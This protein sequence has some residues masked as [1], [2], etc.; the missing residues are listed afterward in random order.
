MI[1]VVRPTAVAAS[2]G[3]SVSTVC[4]NSVQSN[5]SGF[6]SKL[7]GS[8]KTT[9]L[10][11]SARVAQWMRRRSPKP[12]IGGSSPPVGTPAFQSWEPVPHLL[13]SMYIMYDM[14]EKRGNKIVYILHKVLR[15]QPI[16]CQFIMLNLV[17]VALSISEWLNF[18]V[19]LPNT[20]SNPLCHPL[21]LNNVPSYLLQ[22]CLLAGQPTDEQEFNRA[23]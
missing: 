13:V 5:S 8:L 6:P 21:P 17:A 9:L 11:N 4:L 19:S 14:R 16:V 10:L 22:V 2:K 20:S 3:I 7:N 18:F 12:K 23:N 1:L 15:E